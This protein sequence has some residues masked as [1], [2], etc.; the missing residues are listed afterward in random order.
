M[1][2]GGLRYGMY[3]YTMDGVAANAIAKANVNSTPASC[4]LS[5]APDNAVWLQPAG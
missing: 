3:Y 4:P 2:T 1:D 5:L